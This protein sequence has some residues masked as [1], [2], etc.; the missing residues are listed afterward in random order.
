MDSKPSLT[1]TFKFSTH[2]TDEL[3][4][5][6][7]KFTQKVSGRVGMKPRVFGQPVQGNR[8]EGEGSKTTG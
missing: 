7:A 5:A 2:L 4:M 3:I 6:Q 8:P 1:L